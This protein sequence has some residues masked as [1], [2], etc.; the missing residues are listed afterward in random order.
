MTEWWGWQYLLE[1]G[2]GEL[3]IITCW[4]MIFLVYHVAKIGH[5]RRV[6]SVRRWR[7]FPQALQLA[8]AFLAVATAT[9]CVAAVIWLSR[10]QNES[11]LV[12]RGLDTIVISISRVLS[13]AG[14]LCALRV[15]T[16]P[17]LLRWPWLGAL[18]CGVLY[19][20]WSVA[21]LF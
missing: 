14:F 1:V 15:I 13:V 8:I 20:I 10:Y 2:N 3:A 19:L 21:R 5:M 17:M 16:R 6:W 11:Y 9:F 7:D 18:G 4:T 12:V